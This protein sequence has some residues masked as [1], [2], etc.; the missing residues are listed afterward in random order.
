MSRGE[1]IN[2]SQSR[3]RVPLAEKINSVP[4]VP[5]TPSVVIKEQML[6]KILEAV[7]FYRL[8]VRHRGGLCRPYGRFQWQQLFLLWW[9]YNVFVFIIV[10]RQLQY[11]FCRWS[12]RRHRRRHRQ[13][14][15]GIASEREKPTHPHSTQTNKQT[16]KQTDRSLYLFQQ[17]GP[18]IYST[19]AGA[20]PI[21]WNEGRSQ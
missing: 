5:R 14:S 21:K 15:L 19:E 3:S 6:P 8:V 17:T 10:V 20:N 11:C 7:L 1:A 13:L 18:F 4:K 9:D 2:G 16:N 12:H